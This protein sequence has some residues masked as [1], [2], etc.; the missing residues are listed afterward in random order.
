MCSTYIIC[1]CCSFI[2]GL[3]RQYS[4]ILTCTL[5]CCCLRMSQHK[6]G[7]CVGLVLLIVMCNFALNVENN[8]SRLMHLSKAEFVKVMSDIISGGGDKDSPSMVE[9]E[10][11]GEGEGEYYDPIDP[12]QQTNSSRS[13]TSNNANNTQQVKE[14]PRTTATKQAQAQTTGLS[15]SNNN[16][17][18]ATIRAR[19]V[20]KSDSLFFLQKSMEMR[21]AA[22]KTG[23]YTAR[24][25][26]SQQDNA[27]A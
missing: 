20:V 18:G 23:D 15:S 2:V 9:G 13:S 3:E 27:N 8:E 6:H 11:N 25:D 17:S 12:T 22:Y 26:Y 5:Q 24:T 7:V 21:E 4:Q 14:S 10:N 1:L 19:K 16:M